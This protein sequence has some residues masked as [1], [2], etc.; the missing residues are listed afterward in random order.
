ML[1]ESPSLE[2]EFNPWTSAEARFEEAANRLG[3]DEGLRKVLNMPAREITVHIPVQLDDGRIGVFTGYRVQHSIARGPAKGGIRFAPDVTLDEVRAL[4]AWMTW[5][6][7]VVNIPF[8]G[9]KGGVICDPFILSKSELE[10]ITRRYTAEI[11]DFIG[12]ERDVPAPDV[13]T[14]E[15]TMAWIMDTYSMHVRHT[16]TAV[17]TGKPLNL[18]GSRDRKSTRLNSSHANISYAVF[19]LKKK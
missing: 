5:K 17:V 7:A 16:T 8:G 15:Q 10:K 6:C 11:L 9:G 4:A 13:N 14:N 18:G 12:P 3:L 2:K 19:C 1:V